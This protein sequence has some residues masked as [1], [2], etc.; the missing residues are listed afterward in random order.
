M[1]ESNENIKVLF[2]CMHNSARSQIAEEYLKRLGEGKFEAESASFEPRQIN[3]LVL[4]VM[5]EDGFDLTKK[6][7]SGC[8]GSLPGG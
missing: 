8:M 2:I 6:K 7:Y 5:K 1:Q 4:K 3:P